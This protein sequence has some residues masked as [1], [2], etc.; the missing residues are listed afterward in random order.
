MKTVTFE[1]KSEE[2]GKRMLRVLGISNVKASNGTRLGVVA[3][4]QPGMIKGEVEA[5]VITRKNRI[6][7]VGHTEDWGIDLELYGRCGHIVSV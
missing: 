4:E 6:R 5:R 7:T 1:Q 3:E 2:G